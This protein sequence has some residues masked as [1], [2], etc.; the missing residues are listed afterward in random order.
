MK[1]KEL[2]FVS[3]EVRLKSSISVVVLSVKLSFEPVLF[4]EL[5]FPEL[6]DPELL[7]PELLEPELLF[8]E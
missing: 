1:F 2:S 8:P 6:L 4:P 3:E 7:D 5:L